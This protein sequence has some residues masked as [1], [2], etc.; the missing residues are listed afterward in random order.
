M[1]VF[2]LVCMIRPAVELETIKLILNNTYFNLEVLRLER[3]KN[4][5]RASDFQCYILSTLH[6]PSKVG[7]I[8]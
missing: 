3:S 5:N 4:T 8:T 1:L 7:S 2:S 6:R